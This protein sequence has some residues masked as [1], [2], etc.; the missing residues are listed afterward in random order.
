MIHNIVEVD[1][2]VGSVNRD[3][4]SLLSNYNISILGQSIE[5]NEGVSENTW[6]TA[7]VAPEPRKKLGEH[8]HS[9]YESRLRTW[10]SEPRR[11]QHTKILI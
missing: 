2:G 5:L 10:L 1:L 3:A 7:N 9:W 8:R 6:C 4:R 11:S